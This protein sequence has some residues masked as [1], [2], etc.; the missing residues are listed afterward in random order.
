M[1]DLPSGSSIVFDYADENL[2]KE[3][4]FFN[5]VEN[6]VKWQRQEENR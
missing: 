2:F 1:A 5:R 6:M 3:K 4:G